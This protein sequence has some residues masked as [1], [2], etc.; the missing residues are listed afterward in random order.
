MI[1]LSLKKRM[2]EASEKLP[3]RFTEQKDGALTIEFKVAE[4]KA[5]LTR[6]T[7]TYRA[8]LRVENDK[9]EVRFFE[10]L[11]ETGLGLSSGDTDDMSPGFGSRR[12]R[13]RSPEKQEKGLSRNCLNY[14]AKSTSTLSIT[15][16]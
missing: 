6:K 8:K 5:F 11:K 1:E 3:A 4:R 12:K 16:V 7:L 15:Q 10:T 9:R 14:S 2:I 13:T